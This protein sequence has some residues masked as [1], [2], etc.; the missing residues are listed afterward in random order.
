MKAAE[1]ITVETTV[2]SDINKIWNTWTQPKHI[3]KWNSPSDDWHT[4]KTENDLRK[5]G[6]FN[7]RMEAKDG[8]F[9][10]DYPGIYDEVVPNQK[11][12]YT[13][14]DGRKVEITFEQ[15]NDRV[16]VTEVFEPESQNSVDMQQQGWQAILDNFKTYV[17][18]N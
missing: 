2:K 5:D 15:H 3:K 1:N 14:D 9:G 18:S 12:K 7:S 13:I 16:L 11:I 4:P 6:R 8:S 10:F 17:E